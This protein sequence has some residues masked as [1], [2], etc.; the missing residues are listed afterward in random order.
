M[1]KFIE[2]IF[3]L[4]III[5]LSFVSGK[6]IDNNSLLSKNTRY[7]EELLTDEDSFTEDYGEGNVKDLIKLNYDKVFVFGPY[8]SVENMEEKI[9]F[10]SSKLIQGVSEGTNNILFV[11]DNKEVEYLFGYPINSGYYIDIPIGDYTKAEI[12]KMT[13]IMEKRDIGNSSGDP[14][15]HNYY[16]FRD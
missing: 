14:K 2:W 4:A 5:V 1:R 9:G 6:I 3:L 15:T 16:E 8:E 7:L 12:D 13:Y 10:K 11:K